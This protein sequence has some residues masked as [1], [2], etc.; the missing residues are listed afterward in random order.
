[1]N[2]PRRRLL[3]LA[4]SAAVLPLAAGVRAQTLSERVRSA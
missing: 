3:G 2:P 1:M 4:A